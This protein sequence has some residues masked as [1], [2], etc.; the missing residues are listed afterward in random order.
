MFDDFQHPIWRY[1]F[2]N[3]AV[4]PKSN[5]R[6]HLELFQVRV[7]RTTNVLF[8]CAARRFYAANLLSFSV[9]ASF[10]TCIAVTVC[11]PFSVIV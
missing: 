1:V 2:S 8:L 5:L 7:F 11:R 10:A 9:L 4:S 3:K 6:P